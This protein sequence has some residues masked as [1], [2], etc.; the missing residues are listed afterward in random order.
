MTTPDPA[1]PDSHTTLVLADQKTPST[2][3]QCGA[4]SP[5]GDTRRH[6]RSHHNPTSLARHLDPRHP[7]WT[8]VHTARRVPGTPTTVPPGVLPGVHGA[9][10][11]GEQRG[12]SDRQVTSRPTPVTHRPSKGPWRRN[13][14][15]RHRPVC[16]Y[17]TH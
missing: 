16:L 2:P 4:S 14:E 13:G 6:R 5:L 3:D 11:E 12:R 17:H 7:R 15:E 1:S 9:R 8:T 10:G